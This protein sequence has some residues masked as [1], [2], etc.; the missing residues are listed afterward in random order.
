MSGF[1]PLAAIAR[2]RAPV[3][4]PPPPPLRSLQVLKVGAIPHL[5][6]LNHRS[7]HLY[8]FVTCCFCHADWGHLSGNLFFLLQFGRLVEEQNGAAATWLTYLFTGVGGALFSYLFSTLQPGY[9]MFTL[10]A[11]GA[12]YGLFVMAVLLRAQFSWYRIMEAVILGQFV[13][14]RVLDE[15]KHQITSGNGGGISHL[16]H[17]GGASVAVALVLALV[18]FVRIG[19]RR[20]DKSRGGDGSTAALKAA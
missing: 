10:G 20:L 5:L 4:T 12:V 6:Y 16:A 17:I 2:R 14:Q 9:N 11:S 8:Q 13:V 18:Y 15:V 7:P 19:E 1:K 3:R